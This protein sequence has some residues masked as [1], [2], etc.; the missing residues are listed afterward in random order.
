MKRHAVTV[1]HPNKMV[2]GEFTNWKSVSRLFFYVE[3]AQAFAQEQNTTIEQDHGNSWPVKF[4]L[5]SKPVERITDIN[6]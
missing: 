5:D 3:N 6:F 1:S 2:K 4:L